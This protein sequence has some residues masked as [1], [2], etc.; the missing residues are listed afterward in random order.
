MALCALVREELQ[1]DSDAAPLLRRIEA[2]LARAV[3]NDQIPDD[4]AEQPERVEAL[5][6]AGFVGG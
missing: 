6:R 5:R 4:L 2:E 3:A 1:T